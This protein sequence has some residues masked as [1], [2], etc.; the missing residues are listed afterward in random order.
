[1][2]GQQ[3]V[4]GSPCSPP[5]LC[6]LPHR[7][8]T[9]YCSPWASPGFKYFPPF[10]PFTKACTNFTFI[11]THFIDEEIKAH[12]HAVSHARP[13]SQQE[14]EPESEPRARALNHSLTLR[15][16]ACVSPV[17]PAPITSHLRRA[18][19]NHSCVSGRQ[20]TF[21]TLAAA[22]RLIETWKEKKLECLG[23]SIA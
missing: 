8:Y 17:S 2:L 13:P 20:R 4:R 15:N 1:M 14:A 10:F 7:H 16:V 21:L 19:V 23:P 22:S 5:S 6:H 3:L 9:P 12:R 18:M 11:T